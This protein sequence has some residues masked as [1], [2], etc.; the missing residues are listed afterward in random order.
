MIDCELASNFIT[1]V[2]TFTKYNINIMDAKGTIIAS[3]D[4]DRI[5]KYHEIAFNLIQS[6]E[7]FVEVFEDDDYLGVKRG[8]SVLIYDEGKP[9]GVLG[10]TGDPETVHE[11]AFAMKA[12]FELF[13][14]YEREIKKKISQQTSEERLYEI[15]FSEV[16]PNP[17]KLESMAIA[18]GY[19]AKLVRIPILFVL[20]TEQGKEDVFQQI[21][22]ALSVQ[23][24]CWDIDKN[25]VLLYKALAGDSQRI[26]SSWREEIQAFLTELYSKN[27]FEKALVGS[28]QY[29]LHY[30][31][32]GENYCLSLIHI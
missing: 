3:K 32:E 24:M 27:V 8:I 6:G 14:Q 20:G 7:S 9:A 30:Y 19:S 12:S 4:E 21:Q 15:L 31:K 28:L 25:H 11:I 13:L 23:D 18:A 26:L 10:M 5:G 1:K 16:R 17:E 29:R 22:T 2:S